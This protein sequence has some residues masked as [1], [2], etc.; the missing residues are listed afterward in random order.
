[1]KIE[2]T[3]APDGYTEVTAR[4]AGP[5]GEAVEFKT[6]VNVPLD[7]DQAAAFTEA[8]N[9]VSEAAGQPVGAPTSISDP[10]TQ[11]EPDEAVSVASSQ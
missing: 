10:A 5:G 4:A 1:M 11:L 8:I 9:N 3:P 7:A 6:I 2:L